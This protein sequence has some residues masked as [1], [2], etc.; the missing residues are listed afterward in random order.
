MAVAKNIGFRS[1]YYFRQGWGTYFA[2]IFAAINTLVVTYYLAI[3]RA[4]FLKEVF[5]SF[6]QYI[7]I[8]TV[9]GIPL[10]VFIG[11][12]HYKKSGAYRS[13]ADIIFE[14]NPFVRRMLVNTE[15]LIALNLALTEKIIKLSNNEK[16]TQEEINEISKLKNQVST[17][18]RERTFSN[19]KDF[20][21]LKKEI[22]NS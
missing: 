18:I 21:F 1:W 9:I 14:A 22:T 10:L 8:V 17:L 16:L 20:E 2:F 19:N 6:I 11:Y 7:I 12:L 13:E 5:P 4:P 3:E 15:I